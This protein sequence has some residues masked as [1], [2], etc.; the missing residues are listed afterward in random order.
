MSPAAKKS[1]LNELAAGHVVR[2]KGCGIHGQLGEMLS[3]P[4]SIG[5]QAEIAD[6]LADRVDQ[7]LDQGALHSGPVCNLVDDRL[8][9]LVQKLLRRAHR[10]LLALRYIKNIHQVGI[11]RQVPNLDRL[12]NGLMI[13]VR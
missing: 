3:F 12:R 13:E 10:L 9:M 6:A 2:R 1:G 5:A 4:A 7:L 11:E 8:A